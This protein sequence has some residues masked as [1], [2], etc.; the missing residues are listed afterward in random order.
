MRRKKALKDTLGGGEHPDVP[1]VSRS[2]VES[3]E[4]SLRT[5][6][7]RRRLAQAN[8]RIA[9]MQEALKLEAAHGAK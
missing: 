8:R 6:E 3:I 2:M 9:K 1:G 4:A 7:A 5:P